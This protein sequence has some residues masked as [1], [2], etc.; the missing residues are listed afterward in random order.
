MFQHKSGVG[1]FATIVMAYHQTPAELC[2]G[3]RGF[4]Q[5]GQERRAV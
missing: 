1:A 2:L 5:G 4:C 3:H